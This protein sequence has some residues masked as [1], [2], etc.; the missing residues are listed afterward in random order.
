MKKNSI[1]IT[2]VLQVNHVVTEPVD[3]AKVSEAYT[4]ILATIVPRYYV[5]TIY[6]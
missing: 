1:T 5:V 6:W 3:F 4:N 2:Y